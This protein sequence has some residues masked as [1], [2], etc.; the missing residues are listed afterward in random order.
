MNKQSKFNQISKNIKSIKIQGARNIAKA[1]FRAYKLVP[2]KRAKQKLLSLRPTEPMLANVLELADKISY[3]ELSKKLKENQEKINKFVY[4]QIKNNSVIF[5]Y[6]HS[7]TVTN[8]LIYAKKKGK[9][10]EVYNTETRPLYQGRKT[11]RELKNAGIKVTMFVDS[12]VSIALTKSQET[13]D[14]D[15]VLL[16]AD[17]ILKKGV[18]NK[19]GSGMISQIAKLNKIPFII[20]AESWKYFPNNIKIEQRDFKEVWNTTRKIK[21][22]NPAFELIPRKNISKIICELGN[23]SYSEFLRKIKN[24][25]SSGG[26]PP[27]S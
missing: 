8:S 5:T 17:A 16:G 10:F 25:L 24:Y 15:L 21:I 26:I 14:V 9:K 23:F 6:C 20:V 19:V 4:K 3:R 27:I 13:K 18:I 2:T 7:S 12:A 1:G 22:K 11:A